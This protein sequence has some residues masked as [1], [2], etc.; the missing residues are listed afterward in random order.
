MK[1][2]ILTGMLSAVALAQAVEYDLYLVAGQSNCDGRADKTELTGRLAGWSGV[3]TNVL[4][5]YTNPHSRDPENPTYQT[6]WTNLMPG[7]GIK[8][9]SESFPSDRYGPELSFGKLMAD[10]YPDRNAAF[11][12]VSRGGTTL[13]SDWSPV[14]NGFM[15]QTFTNEVTQAMQALTDAGHTLNLRGMI[16]H[17]GESDINRTSAEFSADLTAFLSAVRSFAGD[18]ELPVVLGELAPQYASRTIDLNAVAAVD[19]Y[20]SIVSAEDLMFPDAVHFDSVSQLVL[21]RRYAAAIQQ[22]FFTSELVEND[23]VVF[24]GDSITQK[25]VL[26]NG[27]VT[28]FADAAASNY[29]S[30]LIEVIGAGVSGDKMADLQA[31]LES[32]VLS[33]DPTVVV[34]YIGINDVWHWSKPDPGTGLPR[35]GTTPEN[36]EAGMLDLISRIEAAGA[37]AVICTPTVIGE[38]CDP[39]EVNAVMLEEFAAIC[40]TVARTTGSQLVDLRAYFADY[41]LLNNTADATSGILTADTVHLNDAGN[42]VVA[43]A[44]EDALMNP[45][46]DIGNLALATDGSEAIFSWAGYASHAYG[47]VGTTN[48]AEGAW[49]VLESRTG[50]DGINSMTNQMNGAGAYYRIIGF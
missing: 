22:H 23:T 44:L 11:I 33:H 49:T 2:L 6:G 40:R 16:W 42:R 13:Y 4:I 41:L 35:E 5:H 7:F 19:P 50:L 12:K 46:P 43:D 37:R 25:G 3:Q 28:L 17:Q 24:F 29:P 8:Y 26:E 10:S 14:G 45:L 20:T 47:L 48:L 39:D 9:T 21:G 27:Y 36:Y 32:D 30:G 31:R 18:A 38:Q 1:R 34:I 15:W